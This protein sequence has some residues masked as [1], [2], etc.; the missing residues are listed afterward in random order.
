[1]IGYVR[2]RHSFHVKQ[3]VLKFHAVGSKRNPR[4]I[5]SGSGVTAG[6][7]IAANTHAHICA[8]KLVR[9]DDSSEFN[10]QMRALVLA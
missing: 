5:N 1:M 9:Q 3:V 8:F 2:S 4:L 6:H 10:Q 7:K